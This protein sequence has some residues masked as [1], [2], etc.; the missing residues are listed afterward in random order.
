MNS[1]QINSV[2]NNFKFKRS[3]NSQEHLHPQNDENRNDYNPWGDKKHEF[4]NL[5]LITSSFNS[6]QSDDSINTKF[7]RILDQISSNSIESIKLYK[8]LKHC[9]EDEKAWTIKVMEDHQIEMI[10]RLHDSY[11]E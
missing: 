10:Q 8:I 6:T 9:K 2:I 3:I 5:F 11:K 7:G 1:Q 4:G